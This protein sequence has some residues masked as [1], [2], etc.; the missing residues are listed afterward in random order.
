MNETKKEELTLEQKVR[1]YVEVLKTAHKTVD[2]ITTALQKAEPSTPGYL[3]PSLK[4]N[5]SYQMGRQIVLTAI[6]KDLDNILPEENPVEQP[7]KP[8]DEKKDA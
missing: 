8:V 7:A 2:G 6:L 3:K 4:E 5:L 1:N